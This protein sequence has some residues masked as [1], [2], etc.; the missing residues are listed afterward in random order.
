[1]PYAVTHML[2]PMLLIDVLKHNVL[3]IKKK[4]PNRYILYAG[5]AGLLPDIDI[6]LSQIFPRF[7]VH[8]GITHTVWFPLIFLF[9]FTL[10]HLIKKHHLSTISLMIAIGISSHIILDLVTAGSIQLFY[11]ISKIAFAIN[12]IP[13]ANVA[14]VYP[15]MDAIFLFL[16]FLRMSLRKRVRDMF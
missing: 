13:P 4:L 5:L 12:L 11:P 14:L 3:K 15:A 8:R 7:I 6:L 10:L 2:V 16:W 9:F 1:M